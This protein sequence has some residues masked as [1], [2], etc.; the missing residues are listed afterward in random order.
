MAEVNIPVEETGPTDPSLTE[1]KETDHFKE[2]EEK[3]ELGI[4]NK[5]Y[6]PDKF[7]NEDG[8]VNIDNLAKSYAE[9]EKRTS[10]NTSE[11]NKDDKSEEVKIDDRPFT[12]DEIQSMTEEMK[13]K[14]SLSDETYEI[15]AKRG[16]PRNLAESY[17]AGQQLLA[18][19]MTE[20]IMAPVGGE[21]NY[22][23]LISWAGDNLPQEDIDAYDKIMFEGDVNQKILAVEGLAARRERSNPTAPNLIMGEAGRAPSSSAFSSW[24]QVKRAMRDPRYQTDESYRASVENRISMSDL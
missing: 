2:A 4:E 19:Q 13:E 8:T 21:D 12:S 5:T 7:M 18:D 22:A 6:I 20:K 11:P 10:T 17:V 1:G 14:G 9:L 3:T 24:D 15:L 23:E 16:M